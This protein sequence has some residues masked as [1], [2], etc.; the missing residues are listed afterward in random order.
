MG[1]REQEGRQQEKQDGAGCQGK[2]T[3]QYTLLLP[4][5]WRGWNPRHF[6]SHRG[7]YSCC[8]TAKYPLPLSFFPGI[9][10]HMFW[11]C[12]LGQW[13]NPIHIRSGLGK[14]ERVKRYCQTGNLAPGLYHTP[15]V[16]SHLSLVLPTSG[17][18]D[19]LSVE[20]LQLDGRSCVLL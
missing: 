16:Q 11:V 19:R 13:F 6:P 7:G 3:G 15:L 1:Q 10:T 5:S 20:L 4:S 12:W 8:S 18:H 14:D 2:S 17:H 9:E